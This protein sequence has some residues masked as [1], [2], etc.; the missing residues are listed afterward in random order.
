MQLDKLIESFGDEKGQLLFDTMMVWADLGGFRPSILK[1][2]T[3]I[4]DSNVFSVN[5][6]I[7]CFINPEKFS[8]SLQNSKTPGIING[9]FNRKFAIEHEYLEFFAP[10]SPFFDVIVSNAIYCERGRS[11]AFIEF[12]DFNWIGLILIWNIKPN[13]EYLLEIE[14]SHRFLYKIQGYLP[15]EQTLTIESFN[16]IDLENS[17]LLIKNF[18][19]SRFRYHGA[20]HLGKR[21][22]DHGKSGDMGR[23]EN[24]TNLEYFKKKFPLQ[25]W[26]VIVKNTYKKNLKTIRENFN[27]SLDLANLIRDYNEKVL[28]VIEANKFYSI[29]GLDKDMML[30]IYN[31]IYKGLKNPIFELDS[32]S[33]ACL[34]NK[35]NGTIT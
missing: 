2:S 24:L 16:N 10:G 12:A 19:K 4:F 5:S 33:Y 13:L 17:N 31:A 6:M 3:I 15:M 11:S 1:Q 8:A 34:I 14:D 9:T 7:N 25:K 26:E 18:L 22:F 29:D 35:D 23:K 30:K 20:I 21:N 27:E 32:I 28:G